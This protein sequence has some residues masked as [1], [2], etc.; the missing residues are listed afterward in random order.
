VK[1]SAQDGF[2]GGRCA[3]SGSCDSSAEHQLEKKR[4]QEPL[5]QAPGA[6]AVPNK[7]V[8]PTARSLRWRSGFR[9]RLTPGV[10]QRG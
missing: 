6:S 1:R 10:R 7:G 9:Q 2:S 4:S 5:S 8:Q 3:L